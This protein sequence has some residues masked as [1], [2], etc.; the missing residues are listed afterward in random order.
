MLTYQLKK[1]L[2]QWKY[3]SHYFP[4]LTDEEHAYFEKHTG[5]VAISYGLFLTLISV[6]D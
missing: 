2:R 3:K 1:T 4:N 6:G 5:I